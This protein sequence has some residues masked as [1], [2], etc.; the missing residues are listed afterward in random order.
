MSAP[1]VPTL[2]IQRWMRSVLEGDATIVAAVGTA[3]IYPNI[4]ASDVKVRHITH[5]FGG[6]NNAT[7]ARPMR[8]PIAQVAMF[9]DITAWEPSYSQQALQPVMLAIMA[10]LVGDDTRGTSRRFADSGRNFQIDCD[11]VGPEVVPIEATPAGVWAPIRER[12]AVT[13][14]PAA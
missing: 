1:F 8:G 6:P 5:G 10:E 3:N 11:Y 13:L 7:I 2:V 4:S 14:R 12:Y 9:W